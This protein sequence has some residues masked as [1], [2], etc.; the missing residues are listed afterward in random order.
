MNIEIFIRDFE[1]IFDEIEPGSIKAETKFRDLL[2]W[3]SLIA[4][5]V[6]ALADENYN[7]KLTG[8]DIRSSETVED[9]FKKIIAKM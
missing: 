3:S 4:L 5:S 2:E 1:S 6:I 9:I 8:D 7:I